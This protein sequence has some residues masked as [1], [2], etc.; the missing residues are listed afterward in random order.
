VFRLYLSGAVAQ[1]ARPFP[2][3]PPL[4]ARAPARKILA[5]LDLPARAPPRSPASGEPTW[6][7][8]GA[9]D[10]TVFTDAWG[11]CT[12]LGTLG[13][14]QRP[15]KSGH[16]HQGFAVLPWAHSVFSCR[17]SSARFPGSQWRE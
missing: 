10:A 3:R 5:C 1:K 17:P 9:W 4:T 6:Q 12:A 16:G 11:Y 2:D 13:I 8:S 15:R 7:E 14:D